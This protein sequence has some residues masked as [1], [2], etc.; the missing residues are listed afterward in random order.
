M[1]VREKMENQKFTA[2]LHEVLQDLI[3]LHRQLYEVMKQ[4]NEALTQADVKATYE[5]AASKE[6]IIHWIHQ[7]ELSRQAVVYALAQAEELKNQTPTLKELIIYFQTRNA[8]FSDQL[9]IDLNSLSVLVDRIQRQ[10]KQNGSLVEESLK[11]INNMKRN[12][13]GES[14][15]AKTYNQ[16]GQKNQVSAGAD[17][18]RLISKEV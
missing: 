2:K 6:A 5:A 11:H 13:F 16:H 3:G 18:P 10:N 4:E 17:G 7:G 14:S 9:Q 15:P 12:I 8:E 1:R